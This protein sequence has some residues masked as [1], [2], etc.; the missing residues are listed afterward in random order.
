MI[1]YYKNFS[2]K[3]LFYVDEN[4]TV[5][6]EQWKDIPGFEGLYQA[7]DL[8]RIKSLGNNKF[9][10]VKILKG[11]IG[12]RY[13]NV[14]LSKNKKVHMNNVH[15]FI[16]MTFLNHIPCGHEKIVDHKINENSLDN[17]V[18]NLQ[19]IT[20]RE[21]DSKDSKSKS[22]ITGVSITKQG[23]FK[24]TIVFNKKNC[25]LGV[26]NELEEAISVRE[27]AIKIHSDGGDYLSL[28]KKQEREVRKGVY[29][30][31]NTFYARISINGKVKNLGYFKTK[32]LAY[33]AREK[34]LNLLDS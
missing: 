22:N 15:I 11:G 27:K 33:E 20:H 30:K 5:Q 21:N 1:E 23:K 14:G 32:E 18:S 3:N 31:V 4:G 12:G 28:K 13:R 25:Y 24:V 29:R 7:S 6:E 16:A 2:L 8:G 19:I 34:A 10:S 9:K 17:S 26:F